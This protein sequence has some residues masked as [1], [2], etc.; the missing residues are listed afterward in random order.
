M[1]RVLPGNLMSG[2]RSRQPITT[3]MRETGEELPGEVAAEAAGKGGGGNF[4]GQLRVE[5]PSLLLPVLA[6]SLGPGRRP[7]QVGRLRARR[8]AL[9]WCFFGSRTGSG[10]LGARSVG[11]GRR[12]APLPGSQL[13]P[14]AAFPGPRSGAAWQSLPLSRCLASDRAVPAARPRAPAALQHGA[15][16][17]RP[18]PGGGLRFFPVLVLQ[19]V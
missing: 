4:R 8:T 9:C 19:Q 6:G 11:R 18:R 12:C 5:L 17:L 7:L 14:T 13:P 3:G 15:G 1:L 10:V 2:R 16:T